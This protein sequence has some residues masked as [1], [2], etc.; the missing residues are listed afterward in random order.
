[1]PLTRRYLFHGHAAALGGRIVRLGEGKQAKLV[2]DGFIDLPASSL[3]VVG[4][5]S[6]AR[7][8]GGLLSGTASQVVRFASAHALSEGVFDD[9]KAHFAVTLGQ[10]SAESLTTT[11]KVSAEVIDLEVGLPDNVRMRVR[12]IRGGLTSRNASS[13]GETPVQLDGDTV[14][15]GV[16]F[17]DAAGRSYTLVVEVEPTVYREHDT[18]SKLTDA[19]SGSRFLKKFGHTL[20]LGRSDTAKA[21]PTAPV[22]TRTDSGDVQGTIIKPLRWRG[23]EFPGSKIDPDTRHAVY[24]PGLGTIYFGEITVA[25]QSRRL[26]M[27]RGELGSP[28]GGAFAAIDVQDNGSWG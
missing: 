2:K 25:H 7:L 28:A 22:L 15:D 19:A 18:Y 21:I 5:R 24:I 26:T 11:T 6:Q 8:D 17:L 27:V 13:S 12:R 16:T 3:T 10:R 9:L 20:F 1:M 4:G 23:A 14:F